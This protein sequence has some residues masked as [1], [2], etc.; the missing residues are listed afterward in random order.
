MR[1]TSQL[2]RVTLFSLLLLSIQASAEPTMQQIRQMAE[3]G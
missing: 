3:Q 2:V 1:S